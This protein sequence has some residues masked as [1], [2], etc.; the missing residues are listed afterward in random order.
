MDFFTNIYFIYLSNW[1]PKHVTETDIQL[2]KALPS[3]A[4]EAI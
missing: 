1:Y 3:P 2:P 4:A